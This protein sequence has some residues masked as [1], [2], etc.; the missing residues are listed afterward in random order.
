MRHK[1]QPYNVAIEALNDDSD[2]KYHIVDGNDPTTLC[3]QWANSFGNTGIQEWRVIKDAL[4]K[5]CQ[6]KLDE[7]DKR[8]AAGYKGIADYEQQHKTE[9]A[10]LE[11]WYRHG[12][13]VGFGQ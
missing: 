7:Y 4:C 2:Y 11:Y 13:L 10:K 12:S 5:I 9:L 1:Y 8:I 6:A 3:Y